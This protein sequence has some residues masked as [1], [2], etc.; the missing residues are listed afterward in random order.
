MSQHRPS[1]RRDDSASFTC[2]KVCHPTP[3][4]AGRRVAQ[5]A[6]LGIDRRPGKLKPYWCARCAAWHVG[7]A[8]PKEGGRRA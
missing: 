5:L 6:R 3:T 7:H 8:N 4:D 1:V 2:G